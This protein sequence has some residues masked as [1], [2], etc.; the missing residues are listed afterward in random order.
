LFIVVV[1]ASEGGGSKIISPDGSLAFILALFLILVYL[2]NQIL[3]KP[4][5]K[6]LDERENLTEGAR[7]EARA[8][9]RQ[10]QELMA[11]YEAGIKRARA[12][13][14]GRI[15]RARQQALEWRTRL[16]EET[17]RE[18]EQEIQTAKTNIASQAEL[19]RRAL[20]EEARNLAL[21]ISRAVLGSQVGGES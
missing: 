1:L 20:K 6:I 3:F 7:A 18:A 21:R 16:I 2:L 17:K 11:E 5:G 8:A 19:A 4:I 9:A 13:G 10:C 15:E 14:Y 12:E